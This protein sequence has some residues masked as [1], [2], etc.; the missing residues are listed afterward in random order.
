ADELGHQRDARAAR[1]GEGARAV[2]G[3]ADYDS[4]GGELVLRLDDG[5][6][7]LAS[8][9]INAQLR[10][11]EGERFGERRGRRDRV[12]RA[13]RRATVD[14]A[15]RGGRV[16]VDE[17]LVADVV[18]A[19]HLQAERVLQVLARVVETELQRVQVRF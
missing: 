9:L 12:P 15:E 18:G 1:G 14:A 7:V 17:D 3:G 4:Y 10:A 16:A 19:L 13:H 8:A 5:E 11:V 2:P 6:L